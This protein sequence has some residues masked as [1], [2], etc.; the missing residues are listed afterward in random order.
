M[1]L[2]KKNGT[3]T[4]EVRVFG[5]IAVLLI[6]YIVLVGILGAPKQ[7]IKSVEVADQTAEKTVRQ[8][9]LT[10]YS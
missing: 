1:S 2:L 5:C 10:P 7:E 9:K 6:I 8:G 4:K 3:K